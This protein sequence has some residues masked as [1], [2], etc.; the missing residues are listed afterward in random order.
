MTGYTAADKAKYWLFQ[1]KIPLTKILIL[2]NMLTFVTT[3]LF[4]LVIVPIMLGFHTDMALKWPWGALTYPAIGVCCGLL[5][6]LFSCFWMWIAGGSM[7]RAWGTARFGLFFF[8][9]ALVSALGLWLGARVTGVGNIDVYG[10]WLPLAPVTVA[11]ALFN[12]E[13]QVLFAFVIPIKLK[14]L[15][16]IS[17]AA[18]LIEYGSINLVLGLFSLL[19]CAYAYWYVRRPV[20]SAPRQ[21]AQVV[22]VYERRRRGLNPF[23]GIKEWNDRRKLK[24]LFDRSYGEDDERDMR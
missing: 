15:A 10:L 14:Y 22:R 16:I 4:K 17:V 11:F 24:K 2:L 3:V 21:R 23:A 6:L 8:S 9:G 1:D 13:Q 19:G 12:P 5:S 18:V 20:R 7:E